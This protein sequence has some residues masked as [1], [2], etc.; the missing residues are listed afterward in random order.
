MF[1]LALARGVNNGWIRKKTIKNKPWPDGVQ[2][3]RGS[4]KMVAHRYM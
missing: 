1:T 3:H 4:V 2:F